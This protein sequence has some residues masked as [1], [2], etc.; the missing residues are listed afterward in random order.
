M[1]LTAVPSPYIAPLPSRHDTQQIPVDRSSG[2]Y[3]RSDNLA[4]SP[5]SW[6]GGALLPCSGNS[7]IS[8]LLLF[9]RRETKHP[10]A[11]D[12][13]IR[14]N[15]ICM[16]LQPPPQNNWMSQRMQRME[17]TVPRQNLTTDL[18]P[19]IRPWSLEKRSIT[20]K[21]A[22][23]T[24]R[25]NRIRTKKKRNSPMT[26]RRLFGSVFPVELFHPPLEIGDVLVKIVFGL[27]VFEEFA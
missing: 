4:L 27:H 15:S 9:R 21:Q 20:P 11:I 23:I 1:S 22:R 10:I 17:Q 24:T 13:L 6:H 25:I 5:L 3:R 18:Y 16:V 26:S 19:A 14:K 12:A 8:Y 7:R 2:V